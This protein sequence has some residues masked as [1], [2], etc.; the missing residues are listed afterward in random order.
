MNSD[1]PGVVPFGLGNTI[2]NAFKNQS[3]R[4]CMLL[5]TLGAIPSAFASDKNKR[6]HAASLGVSLTI[7]PQVRLASRA[8][9]INVSSMKA[10]RGKGICLSGKQFDRFSI[11]ALPHAFLRNMRLRLKSRGIA[12]SSHGAGE[13][14]A[15]ESEPVSC[16]TGQRS[17]QLVFD[18]VKKG[19]HFRRN[20]PAYVRIEPI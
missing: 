11:K 9:A 13:P 8:P 5:A 7:L 10:N 19:A 12:S 4:A 16:D 20:D 18:K 1:F 3:I 2:V 15:L 6:S 17:V 14:K